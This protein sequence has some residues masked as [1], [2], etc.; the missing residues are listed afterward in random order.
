MFDAC[1]APVHRYVLRR[2]GDPDLADDVVA[3]VFLAAWRGLERVPDDAL[4]WLFNTARGALS[5]HRRGARRRA[6]LHSAVEAQ[7][8]I[9]A[10]GEPVP[11]RALL[12]ALA[13]LGDAAREALLLVAWEGLDRRRAAR[14]MGCTQAAFAARLHRAR[15]RLSALLEAPRSGPAPIHLPVKE[16]R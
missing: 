4:P 1:H 2:C 8:L 15:R 5:N 11:D 13:E 10:Q 9:A 16:S 14:A 6:A 7:A 3:D 12:E